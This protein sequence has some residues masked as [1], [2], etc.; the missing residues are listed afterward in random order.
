MLSVVIVSVLLILTRFFFT[1]I[2]IVG[3]IVGII[4]IISMSFIS[5]DGFMCLTSLFMYDEMS[6][7][8]S[9]LRV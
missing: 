2:E 9:I 7:L 3:V 5:N 4:L 6:I 8:L 1:T